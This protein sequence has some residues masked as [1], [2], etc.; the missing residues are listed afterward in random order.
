[1]PV[2]NFPINPAFASDINQVK[3]E[4]EISKGID[5]GKRFSWLLGTRINVQTAGKVVI[6]PTKGYRQTL[7]VDQDITELE[8]NLSDD[9]P[10]IYLE[11]VSD[12]EHSLNMTGWQ[13]DKDITLPNPGVCILMLMHSPS[14]GDP[15][16]K[17]MIEM[18]N[19]A[20]D[21]GF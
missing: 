16:K 12:G 10:F 7:L 11:V 6:D 15:R 5:A 9:C 3:A 13:S 19:G 8:C 20:T 21:R 17:Y 1:M 4:P 14:V 2:K 18:I